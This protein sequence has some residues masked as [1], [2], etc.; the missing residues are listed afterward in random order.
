M[1]YLHWAAWVK[2]YQRRNPLTYFNLVYH[3]GMLSA[4]YVL[5][6]TY[7][8]SSCLR[9]CSAIPRT[10]QTEQLWYV[11]GRIPKGKDPT[12]VDQNLIEEYEIDLS[13][14][15]RLTLHACLIRDVLLP[16]VPR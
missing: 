7:G 14:T 3:S 11:T 15:S 6:R 4:K 5:V 8:T 10:K 12:S 16:C 2:L 9:Q 1:E 13:T